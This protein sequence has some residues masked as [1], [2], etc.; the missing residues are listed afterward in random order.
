MHQHKK[1]LRGPKI[2]FL[3]SPKMY[4]YNCGL[5]DFGCFNNFWCQKSILPVQQSW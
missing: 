4:P 5:I 2:F 1:D 3:K